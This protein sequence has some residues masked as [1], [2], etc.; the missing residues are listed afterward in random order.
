MEWDPDPTVHNPKVPN[1]VTQIKINLIA[2]S[3]VLLGAVPPNTCS[4]LSNLGGLGNLSALGNLSVLRNLGD[5]KSLIGLSSLSDLAIT[6][7]QSEFSKSQCLS[8]LIADRLNSS[9]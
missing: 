5:L 6:L 7:T 9:Q 8:D 2:L 4:Y 1:R 3:W